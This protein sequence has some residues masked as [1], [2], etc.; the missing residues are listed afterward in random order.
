MTLALI[1][2]T[3][4]ML[5]DPPEDCDAI[6]HAGDLGPD[7]HPQQWWEGPFPLWAE[8]VGVPIYATFGNHDFF[9]PP[10][11]I[12]PHNFS[13][14]VDDQVDIGGKKVWFSPWVQNLPRWAWNLPN[15]E[16]AAHY[17]RIPDDT[18]LIVSHAP[19]FGYGDSLRNS[20]LKYGLPRDMRV[21]SPQ[22]R[23]RLR[24]LP[25]VSVICGHIHE[26][27]GTFTTDEGNF[28]HNVASVD[29]DYNPYPS[30]WLYLEI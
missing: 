5:P 15:E 30:R 28:V 13:L 25:G 7:R 1:S 3:H 17:A 19:P 4:G 2:D 26:D 22:L 12:C 6:I 9:W 21:G 23:D 11:A 14:I 18:D 16:A 10:L 20:A 29:G 24:E 27:R 8:T